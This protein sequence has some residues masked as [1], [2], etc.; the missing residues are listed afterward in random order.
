[1]TEGLEQRY[2]IKF[3]QKLNDSLVET[4][5]NIQTAF[6]DDAMGFTQIK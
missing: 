4:N 1:M 5:R 3:C 2:C 6:G